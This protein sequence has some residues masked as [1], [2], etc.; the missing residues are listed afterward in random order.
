MWRSSS[1]DLSI[2]VYPF[3]AITPRLTLNRNNSTYPSPIYELKRSIKIH[4]Y[5]NV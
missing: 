5:F 4:L 1:G 3:I 2:M